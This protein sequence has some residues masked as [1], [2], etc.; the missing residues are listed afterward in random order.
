MDPARAREL[1]EAGK[2]ESDMEHA[3]AELSGR[4][5]TLHDSVDALAANTA[6]VRRSARGS[7]GTGLPSLP[8][9]R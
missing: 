2:R 9:S 8:S 3:L 6:T 5:E 4:I 7:R 1:F